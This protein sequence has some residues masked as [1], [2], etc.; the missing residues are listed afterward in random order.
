MRTKGNMSKRSILYSGL[1]L[2]VSFGLNKGRFI[3]DNPTTKRIEWFLRR[4]YTKILEVISGR[5]T[6]KL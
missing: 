6:Q 4:D 5:M 1:H 3:R 2:K